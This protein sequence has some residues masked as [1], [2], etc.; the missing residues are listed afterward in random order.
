MSAVFIQCNNCNRNLQCNITEEA[1]KYIIAVFIKSVV[2]QH[3]SISWLI[4]SEEKLILMFMN[5]VLIVVNIGLDT[6]HQS[7]AVFMTVIL[8]IFCDFMPR[9]VFTDVWP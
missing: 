7:V 8:N 1:D 3:V 4:K 9:Q 2:I 5:C 6:I